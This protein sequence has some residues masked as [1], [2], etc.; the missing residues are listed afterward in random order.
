MVVYPLLALL[1][2][3]PEHEGQYVVVV[4]PHALRTA[5]LDLALHTGRPR[6]NPAVIHQKNVKQDTGFNLPKTSLFPAGLGHIAGGYDAGYYGYLWSLVYAQDMFT[7]FE[8]EGVLS[9]RTGRAYRKDILAVGSSRPEMD[10]VVA[11][12]G[13]KPND[14]AFLRELGIRP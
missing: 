12:L 2:A 5:L 11:F 3:F 8:R 4:I 9:P 13:R 6:G 1:A 7:R 10:S 14:K